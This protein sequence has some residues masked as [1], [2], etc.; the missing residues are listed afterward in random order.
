MGAGETLTLISTDRYRI[1]SAE[2]SWQAA[3]VVL[4]GQMIAPVGML[5]AA[6][7]AVSEGDISLSSD[8]NN[9]MGLTGSHH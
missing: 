1:A 4:N 2:L 5:Q 7:S 3:S 6:V 8:D 9:M